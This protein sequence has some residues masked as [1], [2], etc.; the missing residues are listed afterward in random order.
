[1]FLRRASDFKSLKA[2]DLNG[3]IRMNRNYTNI[4]KRPDHLLIKKKDVHAK[5]EMGSSFCNLTNPDHHDRVF[6]MVIDFD[7]NPQL[8]VQITVHDGIVKV[9]VPTRDS[10]VNVV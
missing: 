2:R 7:T 6:S 9:I 8:E 4:V 3:F 5:S 10:L 1:M